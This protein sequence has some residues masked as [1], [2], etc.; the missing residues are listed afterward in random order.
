MPNAAADEP[1]SRVR[2]LDASE[3]TPAVT[4]PSIRRMTLA[5]ADETAG[6]RALVNGHAPLDGTRP[7]ED[8][9]SPH[10]TDCGW[11]V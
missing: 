4:D 3:N 10:R 9:P 1:A 8:V 7:A 2:H 11:L 5:I 6:T